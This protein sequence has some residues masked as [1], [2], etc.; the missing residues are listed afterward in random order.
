MLFGVELVQHVQHPA[1]ESLGYRRAGEHGHEMAAAKGE[2]AGLSRESRI[3]SVED[4]NDLR[5][6]WRELVGVRAVDARD[7]IFLCVAKRM[8]KLNGANPKIVL[9]GDRGQGDVV[10]GQGHFHDI[11]SEFFDWPLQKIA[12]AGSS[13]ALGNAQAYSPAIRQGLVLAYSRPS[14]S[15]HHTLKRAKKKP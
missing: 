4:F 11:N 1:A 8:S 7:T 5:H 9:V 10:E 14:D 15:R 2:D 13:K 12:K 6:V 3:G